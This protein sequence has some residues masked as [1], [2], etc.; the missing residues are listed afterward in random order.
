MNREVKKYLV[1][2]FGLTW[3]LWGSIAVANQYNF[4]QYGTP[5][6]MIFYIAGGFMPAVSA[7]WWGLSGLPGIYHYGLLKVLIRLI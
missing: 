5:L 7:R 3:I 6:M 2:T 4:L 1:F